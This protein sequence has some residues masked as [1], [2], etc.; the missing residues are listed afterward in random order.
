MLVG[1]LDFQKLTSGYWFTFA[2]VVSWQLK[3]RKYVSL[4]TTDE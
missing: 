1:E 3:L 4:F 2:G